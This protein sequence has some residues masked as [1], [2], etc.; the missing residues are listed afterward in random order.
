MLGVALGAKHVLADI[1]FHQVSF[2]VF[3][4]NF[5]LQGK[6]QSGDGAGA[7][8]L[9]SFDSLPKGPSIQPKATSQL[10]QGV[11]GREEF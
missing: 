4:V 8:L 9:M 2:N 10:K 7:T 6:G 5:C 3:N 1:S 11:T